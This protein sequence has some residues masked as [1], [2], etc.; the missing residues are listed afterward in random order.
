MHKYRLPFIALTLLIAFSLSLPAQQA[1]QRR[2]VYLTYDEAKPIL[3][4]LGEILPPEL[5]ANGDAAANK[6]SWQRWVARSDAGIRARLAQ[7]DEDTLVNFLLF[8]TSYTKQPRV[9]PQQVEALRQRGNLSAT[10][11]PADNSALSRVLDNRIDDFIKGTLTPGGNERLLFA[12]SIFVENNKY[13]LGTTTGRELAKQ[14]LLAALSRVLSEQAGYAQTLEASKLLGNPSE[15]FAERS[16]LYRTRGLSSDTSIFPNFAI[17]EALKAMRSRNLLAA[18]SVRRVAVIGPGLDFTD[19]Q[20][21]YDFYPPQT[22]QPFAVIDSLLRLN[23]AQAP[24]LQLTTFDLSPRINAHINRAVQGAR[25]GR[26][27]VVQLPRDAQAN[28]K[29]EVIRYWES[30]GDRI[31][32]PAPP[33]SVPAG[34]NDVRVRAVRIRPSVVTRV[35]PVD[36]NIVL[37]HPELPV[38]DRYDL[39]VATNIF[40]YYDTFEQSLAMLNVARMLRPGGILISNNALLE[41]PPTPMRSVGYSTAVYSDRADDGDFIV[42]YQRVPD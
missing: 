23:L 31:G 27:Y 14:F 17:E 42:W 15:T 33:T 26:S 41:L 40:V 10:T 34:A 38:L 1:L 20:E 5:R 30:F 16:R 12:R 7:G 6:A 24:A 32:S 18:G 4:L 25:D 21:G 8:G 22:I 2:A 9:T 29:P 11:A 36:T 35:T 37:Q 13:N 19:K 39:I 28:W 3:N